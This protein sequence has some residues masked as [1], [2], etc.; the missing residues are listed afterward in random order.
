MRAKVRFVPWKADMKDQT[1]SG[2][3]SL[4]LVLSICVSAAF[5]LPLTMLEISDQTQYHPDDPDAC[6]A[7]TAYILGTVFFVLGWPLDT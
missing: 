6:A 4:P 7:V 2:F 1:A 5:D 3:V